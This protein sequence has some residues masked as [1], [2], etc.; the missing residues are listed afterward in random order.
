[1]LKN[2]PGR[3]LLQEGYDTRLITMY[4]PD[5]DDLTDSP[6]LR[7]IFQEEMGKEKLEAKLNKLARNPRIIASV[8]QRRRDMKGGDRT[9][10]E[11]KDYYHNIM[12]KKLFREAK[13]NA[14]SRMVDLPEV[15]ALQKINAQAIIKR[16]QKTDQTTYSDILK[17]YK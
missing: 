15:L 6:N 2:S 9:K 3:S 11:N 5:G 16:N 7:A 17:I 8:N 14:W 4:S 10:F 12:I 1:M 13:G